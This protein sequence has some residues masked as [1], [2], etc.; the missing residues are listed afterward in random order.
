MS[1]RYKRNFAGYAYISGPITD[2]PNAGQIFQDTSEY[3]KGQNFKV[4][5]P[6]EIPPPSAKNISKDKEWGYYMKESLTMLLGSD[7]VY[8]LPGWET[9][10]GARMEF[11]LA[12]ELKIPTRLMNFKGKYVRV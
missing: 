7:Y 2:H 1:K 3:L 11:Y 12:T 5:N 10:R 9:S 6:M 8:M 4:F